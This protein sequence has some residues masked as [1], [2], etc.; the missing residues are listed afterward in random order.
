MGNE[1]ENGAMKNGNLLKQAAEEA[2]TVNW[3][4]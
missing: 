1:S 3:F 2:W 4:G